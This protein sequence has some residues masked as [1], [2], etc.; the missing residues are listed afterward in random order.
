MAELPEG[1][2]IDKK[3]TKSTGGLPEGFVV[4]NSEPAKSGGLLNTAFYGSQGAYRGLSDILGAPVDLTNYLLGKVGVPVSETPF[5]GSQS[6][7]SGIN[8]AMEATKRATGMGN[9]DIKATYQDINEVPATYRPSAR[10]GEVTGSTL[11]TLGIPLAAAARIPLVAAREAA[12]IPSG[13]AIGNLWRQ[14]VA[15][16][17][18]NPNFVSSQFPATI[19]QAAGAYGAETIDP[20]SPTAQMVGQLSG[21]LGVGALHAAGQQGTSALGNATRR[22]IEPFTTQ[23]E[24]GAKNAAARALQ[25]ILQ[26]SGENPEAIIANLRRGQIAPGAVAGDQ[27]Q[28]PAIA[29]I[30]G[31]LSKDSTELANAV[32]A[33]RE[34]ATS[35]IQTGLTQAFEPGQQSALTEVAARRQTQFTTNLDNLVSDAETRARE[36]IGPVQPNSPQTREAL[37]TKARSIIDEALGRARATENSFWN[38][39]PKKQEITP[40]NTVDAFQQIKSQMLPEETLNPLLEKVMKRFNSAV[41][42]PTVSE[43]QTGLLDINGNPIVRQIEKPPAPV[44]LGDAQNLR[45]SL[46]EEARSASANND[47]KTARRFNAV[48]NGLLDD[49]STAGG[50]TVTA[51]RDFSRAL[52]DRFSRSFAGD[53]LGTKA[54]GADR[55]RPELSLERAVTGNP[56][57]SAQQLQELQT[58]AAPIAGTGNIDLASQ[59]QGTQAQFMR[60]LSEK[61]IDPSTGRVKPNSVDSF[62]R[63]NGAI[64]QQFPQYQAQLETAR[65]TQ[66]AFQQVMER[67]DSAQKLAERNA[68][69]AKVMKAGEN[70]A[71]A[72]AAAVRSAYPTRDIRK[73]AALAR[74][75]GEEAVAG[76][77]AAVMQ[78]IMDNAQVNGKFSYAKAS[79]SLNSSLSPNGPSLIKSL[80][81]NQILT[82]TQQMQISKFLDQGVLNEANKISP[83]QVSGFGTEPG[84]IAKSAARIFGAKLASAANI[85]GG[86]AGASL[87]VAQIGA[88]IAEKSFAKLPADQAKQF[89]TKALAAETPDELIDILERISTKVEG[90]TKKIPSPTTKALVLLRASIP[91]TRSDTQWEKQ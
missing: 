10:A 50:P 81:D 4:D 34:A 66:K 38:L 64:L 37:N 61:V 89:M 59:M 74:S 17:A 35:N 85:G 14:T 44:T 42:G 87:Q 54:S 63:D 86:G 83:V 21:G 12:A 57:Q 28:S 69:F 39:V 31:Y 77:R 26:Q 62:I 29:G 49:M 56:Q 15:E 30:Q 51:A 22:L 88:N 2:V 11:P 75:G 43:V 79:D 20:G 5:L 24:E 46:L 9:P 78:N 47:F 19:G 76:L 60:S 84:M 73:L 58:A 8:T 32:Q 68:A 25:P 6:I 41:E 48:A 72:V 52:N 3:E 55:I 90:G 18:G 70:P 7:A 33:G 65:D 36:A 23:S 82:A 67:M 71:D 80:R 27:A 53:I 13:S 1:F 40:S 91:R 45:S 16:A